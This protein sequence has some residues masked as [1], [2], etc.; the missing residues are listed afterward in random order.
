M[1]GCDFRRSGNQFAEPTDREFPTGQRSAFVAIQAFKL[2]EEFQEGLCRWSGILFRFPSRRERGVPLQR[3]LECPDSLE[4]KLGISDI[5][6]CLLKGCIGMTRTR[7]Q[8]GEMLDFH[9]Y[10]GVWVCRRKAVLAGILSRAVLARGR[11]S[12]RDWSGRGAR[13]SGG[14]PR[15]RDSRGSRGGRGWRCSPGW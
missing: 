4:L 14:A 12:P 3:R 7:D 15:A 6:S 2:S 5:S 9:R 11:S 10:P 13:R 8:L 1:G